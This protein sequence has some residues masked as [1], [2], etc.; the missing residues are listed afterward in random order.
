MTT[1]R[2]P[3]RTGLPTV[4]QVLEGGWLGCS[5]YLFT[6][7]SYSGKS[8][9]ALGCLELALR[10]GVRC[11][12]VSVGRSGAEC[13]DVMLAQATELPLEQVR[14]G[15]EAVAW[16]LGEDA[17]AR[18]QE[19]R[20]QFVSDLVLEDV[21]GR[22]LAT[23]EQRLRRLCEEQGC[24]LLMVDDV[25]RLD[26]PPEVVHARLDELTGCC[27]LGVPMLV[28]ARRGAGQ[29]RD[30]WRHYCCVM[31]LE[32]ERRPGRWQRA[33]L[34]VEARFE[35]TGLLDLM[36]DRTTLRW[37]EMSPLGSTQSVETNALRTAGPRERA[38]D[39][40]AAQL[41]S[42][43]SQ[44]AAL[45]SQLDQGVA[46]DDALSTLAQAAWAAQ[47]PGQV[48][49]DA[50]QVL[51]ELRGSETSRL[52]VDDLADALALSPQRVRAALV[53][54]AE[55]GLVNPKGGPKPGM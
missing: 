29:T 5:A 44:V 19:R 14:R 42:L 49:S 38:L 16:R 10:Q 27:E 54:L 52:D 35:P 43:Q 17:A 37:D 31:E 51:F 25:A 8:A 34:Y 12:L 21:P 32:R 55:Q 41:V 26:D 24:E 28:V 3:I 33:E 15:D 40:V 18:L 7:G 13:L 53:L 47:L 6:G 45:A 50:L 9:V 39:A 36:G 20:Q 11:G 22:D 48:G 4:D 30:H 1:R 2:E 46:R 23:V